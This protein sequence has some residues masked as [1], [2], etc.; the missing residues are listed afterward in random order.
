MKNLHTKMISEFVWSY[1]QNDTDNPF[2][3]VEQVGKF[4]DEKIELFEL[5]E[6]Q[7]AL[8]GFSQGAMLA[9]HV[10]LRRA[11]QLAGVIGYS[12]A[13]VGE[14]LLRTEVVSR[15]PILLVHGD[16]DNIVP[17]D[18]LQHTVAALQGAGI[19]VN[20]EMRPGLGH[21]LDDRGIML[22]MD[23]LAHCFDVTLISKI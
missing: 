16:M 18:S 15:P 4:I 13:L 6:K 2:N 1:I 14:D 7:V 10:S 19:Q 21:S 5:T 23:F 8:V 20:S 17:P 12:G 3:D 22:G 11:S 9:L